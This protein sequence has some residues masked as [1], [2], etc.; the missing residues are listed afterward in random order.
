MN[1]TC[2]TVNTLETY[3]WWYK[4]YTDIIITC[5]KFKSL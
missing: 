5:T 1:Y 2:S 4:I 3:N